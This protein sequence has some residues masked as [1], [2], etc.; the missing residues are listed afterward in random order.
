MITA[1]S[2]AVT[3]VVACISYYMLFKNFGDFCE[4]FGKFFN[5]GTRN[6]KLD[7]WQTEYTDGQSGSSGIRFFMFVLG[8]LVAG[9]LTYLKLY[10]SY[11]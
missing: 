9:G 11:H 5:S 1:I 10:I 6:E 7:L 3:L 2:I 8:S 4:G